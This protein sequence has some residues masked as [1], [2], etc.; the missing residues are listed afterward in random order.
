MFFNEDGI[1]NIDEMVIESPTFQK[2]MEDGIVT[3][4]E[5]SEQ[6]AKVV[7]LLHNIESKFNEEQVAEIKKLLVEANVLQ[8]AY[9]IYAKQNL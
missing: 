1:L 2:I 3:D 9:N 4:A 7:A 6:S 8:A 5:L